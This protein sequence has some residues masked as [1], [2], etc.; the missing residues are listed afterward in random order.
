MVVR[1]ADLIHPLGKL[2]ARGKVGKDDVASEGEE[3]FGELV[4]LARR[5]GYMEFHHRLSVLTKSRFTMMPEAHDLGI[6]REGK[7]TAA[8]L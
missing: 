3:R 6:C 7:S 5:L 8:P 1:V 4:A 2:A